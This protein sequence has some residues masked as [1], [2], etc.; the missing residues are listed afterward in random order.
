MNKI[1]LALT[2]LSLCLAASAQPGLENVILTQRAAISISYGG[3]TRAEGRSY[4]FTPIFCIFPDGKLDQAGAE[5]LLSSLEIQP[6]LDAQYGTAVVVNPIGDKYDAQADFDAFVKLF[7]L[8]RGPGN[9]KL[10][11]FGQ[12]ATFVNQVLAPKAGGQVAGIL[13]VAGKPGKSVDPAGVPA[14]VAGKSAA[15]VAKPYQQAISEH[16]D[17]PLL[18]V[19]VNPDAKVSLKEVFADAWK[20]VLGKNYRYN[21]YKHTHYEG[22]PFGQY[23]SFELEPYL[24]CESMGIQRIIVEQPTGRDTKQLWYEYWPEELLEGAPEKS[25]PVMVLLHGNMN[26]PRTQAETS[27]FIQVAAQDRFFVIEME[28]QGTPNYQAMGHDGIESVLYQLFAKYPQLDP[29]RVYAEGLSAGSIT[30]TAL[31]IKKSHVFAAVGGHSG[32]IFG[33]PFKGYTTKDILWD[34]A[35]QKRGAV[36]MPYCSVLGTADNVVPYIKPDNWKNNNYLNA[37]NTYEQMNGMDVVSELDFTA[38]PVFGRQLRDRETIVTN[39][40]DGIVVETGQLYK[41]SVPLIKIVAVM[42]YG[43]WNFQPTARIM[44]DFFKQYRRDPVT[45]QLIYLGCSTSEG[46]RCK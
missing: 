24:D 20:Q 33:G 42:D 35:T 23:G 8:Y 11:G 4:N 37:W 6:L 39:K 45:K 17:E 5:A 16:A 19:V 18:Q 27:G 9:L 34:E 28:W 29:S 30:A 41:G 14:Y 40:G 1:A 38:D 13:T 7:N 15:K 2:A 22:S 21:N 46:V 31:G 36:E 43:H 25:V 10:V 44:W 12:G 3:P 32:G 26:D